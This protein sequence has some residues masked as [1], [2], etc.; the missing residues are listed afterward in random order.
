[1]IP[2]DIPGIWESGLAA[3]LE[4]HLQVSRQKIILQ[5]LGSLG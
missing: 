4:C 5:H 2:A 1:M 3:Q